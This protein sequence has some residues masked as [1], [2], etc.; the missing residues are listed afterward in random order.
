[1]QNRKNP[2]SKKEKVESEISGEV[3]IPHENEGSSIDFKEY[4]W[5]EIV[6]H[7]KPGDCWVVI[8]GKVYDL[9][10]FAKVHPG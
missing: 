9:S 4:S 6:Q 3:I 2:K 5:I 8:H 1:M 7:D 10:D